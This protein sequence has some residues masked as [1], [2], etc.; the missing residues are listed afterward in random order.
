ML[1]TLHAGKPIAPEEGLGRAEAP[2]IGVLFTYDS[3][4]KAV[5]RGLGESH[6][7]GVPSIVDSGGWSVFNAGAVIDP[8][9]QAQFAISTRAL[10][11]ETR[12]LALDVIGS[13]EETWENW[14]LQRSLGAPVEP[15]LHY[16]TDPAEFDR[17]LEAGLYVNDDGDA[18]VNFGGMVASSSRPTWIRP[19][20]AWVASIKRRLPAAESLGYRVRF[21]G[22][23]MTT[24]SA[25]DIVKFDGVDSSYWLIS[26][27]RFR[28]LPLFDPERRR[29]ARMLLASAKPEY[30]RESRVELH[31]VRDLLRKHYDTEP[32]AVWAMDDGERYGLSIRSHAY[33]ADAYR[34][35][36]HDPKAPIVYL[37][38][39][40]TK[41]DAPV[42]EHI[43]RWAH[44][45]PRPLR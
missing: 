31:A 41:P 33:F 17:Y 7:R 36:H 1:S 14:A 25:N 34:R 23:G 32:A 22:L 42:W 5:L 45:S 16:G 43:D 28:T 19:T 44:T 29:W 21:H 18:W 38:A 15:T 27:A 24:P 35:R 3:G 30:E 37:A 2:R 13:P 20:M 40:P 12:F 4:D 10:Y 9:L 8:V 26:L 11:P 39:A 6:R